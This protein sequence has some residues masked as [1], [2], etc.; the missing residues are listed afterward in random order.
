MIY[1]SFMKGIRFLSRKIRCDAVFFF[2]TQ[3][4]VGFPKIPFFMLEK[5]SDRSMSCWL[6]SSSN[7]S[8][9]W[10][11]MKGLL[12]GIGCFFFLCFLEKKLLTTFQTKKPSTVKVVPNNNSK[13]GPCGSSPFFPFFFCCW[14]FLFSGSAYHP[15][16]PLMLAARASCSSSLDG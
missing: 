1:S 16:T 4:I 10:V 15:S 8:V 6:K 2:P 13:Q 11:V 9:H 3:R 14:L 5:W 7:N 12:K